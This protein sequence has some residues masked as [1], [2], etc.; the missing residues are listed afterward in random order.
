MFQERELS[1]IEKERD[2]VTICLQSGG[3]P[4][5]SISNILSFLLDESNAKMCKKLDSH[6]GFLR[7]GKNRGKYCCQMCYLAG[8][9]KCH[10]GC[11]IYCIFLLSHHQVGMKI[12]VKCWKYFFV[13]FFHL[14]NILCRASSVFQQVCTSR[15]ANML[16]IISK[17]FLLTHH[18]APVSAKLHLLTRI[19][20]VPTFA[21]L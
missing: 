13:V 1:E 12:V 20:A 10:I 5:K 21:M 7:A 19:Y 6:V 9:S 14:I 3:I 2:S 4:Q 8:S 15:S 11:S 17:H 16:I 18:L